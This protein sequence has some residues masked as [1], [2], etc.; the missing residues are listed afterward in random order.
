MSL[1]NA[2]T[3]LIFAKMYIFGIILENV[4]KQQRLEEAHAI[5]YQEVAQY[6]E[7]V[8]LQQKQIVPMSHI[9]SIYREKL[10][11]TQFPKATNKS[12][13]IVVRFSHNFIT[14]ICSTMYF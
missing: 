4:N 9:T 14:L 6:V 13:K 5:A 11:D 3:H 2:L 10:Q 7:D 12:K 8:V 1:Y